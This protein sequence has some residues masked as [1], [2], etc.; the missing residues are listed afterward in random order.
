M[1]QHKQG[2]KGRKVGRQSRLGGMTQGVSHYRQ[3]RQMGVPRGGNG[4]AWRA[5]SAK[6]LVGFAASL[7][8]GQ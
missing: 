8:R 7:S 4:G 3:R 5:G 1:P 2:K 6:P